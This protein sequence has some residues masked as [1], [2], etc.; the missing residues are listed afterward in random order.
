MMGGTEGDMEQWVRSSLLLPKQP[1]V[2]ICD[3]ME[4]ARD[5]RNGPHEKREGRELWW[6]LGCFWCRCWRGG[7][8]GVGQFTCLLRFALSC[9]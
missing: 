5:R 9:V 8:V 6:W 3:T 7:W 4:G 2:L 1:H